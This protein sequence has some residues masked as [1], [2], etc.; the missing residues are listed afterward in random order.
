MNQHDCTSSACR[1]AAAGA[2]LPPQL[3]RAAQPTGLQGQAAVACRKALTAARAC[4]CLYTAR[5]SQLLGNAPGP[6]EL[7]D[8]PLIL[9]NPAQPQGRPLWSCS[10]HLNDKEGTLRPCALHL[11]SKEGTLRPCALHLYS[12]EGTLRPCAL[13]FIMKEGTLRPCTLHLNKELCTCAWVCTQLGWAALRSPP[14]TF[15]SRPI[16]RA[17][18]RQFR[19]MTACA[20]APEPACS[21]RSA[22]QWPSGWIRWGQSGAASASQTSPAR[23]CMVTGQHCGPLGTPTGHMASGQ[24]CRPMRS[25]AGHTASGQCCRPMST[26][27]GASG[28]RCRLLSMACASSLTPL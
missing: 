24:C 23:P 6:H 2:K 15:I 7:K 26:P 3:R 1:I 19:H 20:P 25:P 4:C 12:K 13:R 16:L 21:T 22:A 11:Y 8:M 5:P 27:A 9:Q 10:L 18:A 14:C 28:L 17:R